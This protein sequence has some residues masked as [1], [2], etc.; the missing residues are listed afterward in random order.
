MMAPA[1]DDKVIIFEI[2]LELH[3]KWVFV[4]CPFFAP[5]MPATLSSPQ[6]KSSFRA[7]PVRDEIRLRTTVT[8]LCSEQQQAT[9]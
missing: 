7:Q 8:W 4:K 5:H 1:L 2:V 3:T 6:S 9:L